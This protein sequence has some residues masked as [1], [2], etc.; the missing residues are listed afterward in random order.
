MSLVLLLVTGT[1]SLP[2]S[3]WTLCVDLPH[4]VW[5]ETEGTGAE[6]EFS[7]FENYWSGAPGI[8]Q[9][10]FKPNPTHESLSAVLWIVPIVSRHKN[11]FKYSFKHSTLSLTWRQWAERVQ[12]VSCLLIFCCCCGALSVIRIQWTKHALNS[13]ICFLLARRSSI[14][15]WTCLRC[16]WTSSTWNTFSQETRWTA[17]SKS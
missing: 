15:M 14:K 10:G 2:A 13:F 16:C 1:L 7:L 3:Q 12:C 8:T 5:I 4:M 11:S 9:N 6:G 17:Q